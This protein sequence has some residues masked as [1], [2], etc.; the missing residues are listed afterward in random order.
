VGP[1]DG[2]DAVEKR[3]SI[4]SARNRNSAVKTIARS[5]TDCDI[6]FILDQKWMNRPQVGLEIL[7]KCLSTALCRTCFSV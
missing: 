4:S 5:N 3:K 7:G 1:K 2:L 6:C